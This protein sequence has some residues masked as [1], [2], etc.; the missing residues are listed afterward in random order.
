[1]AARNFARTA[2]RAREPRSRVRGGLAA[3]IFAGI[4]LAACHRMR[5][6]RDRREREQQERREHGQRDASGAM[7]DATFTILSP[8]SRKGM[9]AVG[10]F[11]PGVKF[12]S[13]E[14]AQHQHVEGALND[15]GGRFF[16]VPRMRL[17][18]LTV[19]I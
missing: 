2:D 9:I 1:M 15:V 4:A 11:F 13:A 19:K 16:H 14:D 6:R 3:C 17:F 7:P 12:A 10:A 5:L 8:D 18:L